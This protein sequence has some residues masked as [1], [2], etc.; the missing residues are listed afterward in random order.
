MQDQPAT[1]VSEKKIQFD[2]NLTDKTR[3]DTDEKDL[4]QGTGGK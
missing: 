2:E 3:S 1:E 4:A